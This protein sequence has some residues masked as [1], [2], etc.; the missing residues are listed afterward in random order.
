M[1]LHIDAGIGWSWGGLLLAVLM[2]C[3]CN[4]P[5]TPEPVVSQT[6]APV[7]TTATAAG[8]DSGSTANTTGGSGGT[9]PTEP[10]VCDSV[11]SRA[12]AR[13]IKKLETRI[14]GG[15]ESTQGAHQWMA[16]I[17]SDG[18]RQYCGGSLVAK[19]WV[20]TAAHCQVSKSDKVILGRQD[21]DSTA[22]KVVSIVSVKNHAK[23]DARTHDFDVALLQIKDPP[24][25]PLL[26]T[27]Q[28]NASFV[29]EP[30]L[31]VGWGYTKE[32]GPP[33]AKLREVKVPVVSNETCAAGY[34]PD[35]VGIADTMLCAGLKV[36]GKD[37]C[38]GDSGGPLL[39]QV[40][41]K[42]LQTGVVSFGVGCARPDRYGVYTRLSKLSSWLRAC[43]R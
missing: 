43:M 41:G 25:L 23:Y 29:D 7:A 15:V 2:G 11:E 10:E 16:A 6:S 8:G 38:Q 42:W 18:K 34:Q 27:Y 40:N 30:A 5:S 13:D 36:G 28:G 32:G 24:E 39:V 9:P 19:D 20:L 17:S 31:V 4:K 1:K 33:S 21:L 12:L 3:G 26:E 22:G 35:G 14:V 37:S